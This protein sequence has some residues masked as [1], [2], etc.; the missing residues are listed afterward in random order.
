MSA[1]REI[2]LLEQPQFPSARLLHT[3]R[4]VIA[5]Y[6]LPLDVWTE[7]EAFLTVHTTPDTLA[8][9]LVHVP[10][11]LF[12]DGSALRDQFRQAGVR[13]NY[14]PSVTDWGFVVQQTAFLA[15]LAAGTPEQRTGPIAP[16]RTPRAAPRRTG[17]LFY[18]LTRRSL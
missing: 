4:W 6:G 15:W 10:A 16:A 11:G 7:E 17:R 13:W 8:G 3:L 1:E 9:R 2:L 12:P 5:R 14:V 18:P